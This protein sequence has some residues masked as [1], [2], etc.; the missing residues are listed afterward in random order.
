V[1]DV[2]HPLN[3]RR[4]PPLPRGHPASGE[5]CGIC[6]R[7]IQAGDETT[8][9]PNEPVPEEGR[10]QTVEGLICHW[11]CVAEAMRAARA[12]EAR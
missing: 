1:G 7:A 9:I 2:G 6:T 11:A 10:A 12:A 3:L 4:F 8:L 5:S